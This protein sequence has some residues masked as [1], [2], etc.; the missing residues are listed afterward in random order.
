MSGIILQ[1]TA[2][3]IVNKGGGYLTR[4]ERAG[5]FE[6]YRRSKDRRIGSDYAVFDCPA[7]GA[8]NK[9]NVHQA[10]RK[11]ADDILAFRCWSCRRE[12]EVRRS[13]IA[14]AAPRIVGPRG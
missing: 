5:G 3:K 7:C 2:T 14:I 6:T 10:I 11:V 4:T 9:K 1:T 13:A 8:R 12:V